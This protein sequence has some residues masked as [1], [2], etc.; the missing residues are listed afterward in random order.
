MT[1]YRVTLLYDSDLPAAV[2]KEH[3]LEVINS[4][5]MLYVHEVCSVEVEEVTPAEFPTVQE[6]IDATDVIADDLVKY[7]TLR[8]EKTM[9]AEC[10]V[11][12][13]GGRMDHAGPYGM[14]DCLHC[15]GT[16]QVA[17]TACMKHGLKDCAECH[18]GSS[19]EMP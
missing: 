3:L 17:L 1:K 5:E 16:G 10:P 12:F 4:G 6:Q 8:G 19:P 7:R 13:G 9:S 14:E 15:H 2:I 11:C 18:G